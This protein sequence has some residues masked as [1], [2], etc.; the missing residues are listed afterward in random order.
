MRVELY[1]GIKFTIMNV[2]TVITPVVL[3]NFITL[4]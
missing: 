4:H 1:L 3:M 2:N